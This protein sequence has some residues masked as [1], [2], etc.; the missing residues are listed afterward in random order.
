MA[1]L[2]EIIKQ[3][4]DEATKEITEAKKIEV[5]D[6]PAD[7]VGAATED[8]DD[9]VSKPKLKKELCKE[10][11]DAMSEAELATLVEG[12]E[13]LD[14]LSKTTLVNYIKGASKDQVYKKTAI[15]N[16]AQKNFK[17]GGSKESEDLQDKAYDKINKREKGISGA[18]SK[19]T[20][21][22]VSDQVSALLETE[23]LSEEFKTQAITIFEAAVADRVLL[24]EEELRKEFDTQLAEAKLEL[25]GDID[26]FLSEAILQWKAENEI[27]INTNFKTQM[28]ESFMD[29]LKALIAEHNIELPTGSEN[30]LEVALGE[31]D[32]LNEAVSTKDAEMQ[33]LVEQV[34]ELKGVQ[35]LESFKEKMTKTE[36]DRFVQLTESIK[37]V[38]VTQYEKQ[39]NIVL[40]NFGNTKKVE[41]TVPIVEEVIIP[42]AII[43]ESNSDISKYAAYISKKR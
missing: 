25:D 31:V 26:G 23:G 42:T 43:T 2:E 28:A 35:I 5:K 15:D 21:E 4:L 16:E 30:A 11:L 37:F 34:N 20:K 10:D 40:E 18:A 9:V 12:M 32:K 19:L 17:T 8:S 1:T 13:Q 24:I 6:A 29:G 33:K 14:E 36:F 27:A 3:R 38:D 39:L 7:T 41:K 22:S